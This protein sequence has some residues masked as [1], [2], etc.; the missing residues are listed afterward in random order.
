VFDVQRKAR[1][2][3][4]PDDEVNWKIRNTAGGFI[5]AREG[6]T[7]SNVHPDVLYQAQRA[8]AV[9]PG[10]D[11]GAV[12]V[13]WNRSR[14]GAYVLEINTA[15]GLEGTTLTRYTE[16]C[17]YIQGSR[18]RFEIRWANR[19]NETLEEVHTVQEG[20][21]ESYTLGGDEESTESVERPLQV[22]ARVYLREDSG[23]NNGQNNNPIGVAGTVRSVRIPSVDHYRNITVLWDNRTINSYEVHDLDR[24]ELSGQPP[25]PEQPEQSEQPEQPEQGE[26]VELSEEPVVQPQ[27]D[28][29]RSFMSQTS[30]FCIT[31]TDVVLTEQGLFWLREDAEAAIQND[32][33]LSNAGNSVQVKE[34]SIQ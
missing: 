27:Q 8:I 1:T 2:R 34:L 22:G 31:F 6:V 25:L 19:F 16:L 21:D 17:E 24:V 12:D 26:Q 13:I 20:S 9:I 23:F 28:P 33:V 3:D 11:F 30:V 7:P 29:T 18:Q 32:F 4:V 15:P 5:F 14:G 10:L